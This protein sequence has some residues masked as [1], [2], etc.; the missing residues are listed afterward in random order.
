MSRIGNKIITVPS[1]VKVAVNDAQVSVEGK[2]GKLELTLDSSIKC[3]LKDDQITFIRSSDLGKIRAKHG[4]YRSLVNN[5]VLGV[6]EG[7]KKVLQIEGV[8]YKAQMKG[9]MLVLDLGYSHQVNYEPPAEVTVI[10]T[11]PTNISVEG[12]DKQV[13]GQVA[14]DIRA[15]RKPEPYK[16]KGIRYENEQ[17]RRKQGKKV[18]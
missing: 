4:L 3:E 14:A 1:G 5:M 13:V 6:S 7:F 17:V 18:G 10:T 2:K 8:G 16:G 11:T 15:F 12:I 9:K